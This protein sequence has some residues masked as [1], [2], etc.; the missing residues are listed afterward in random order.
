MSNKE[1]EV[2]N[3]DEIRSIVFTLLNAS[4]TIPTSEV[5]HVLNGLDR[6]VAKRIEEGKVMCKIELHTDPDKMCW[7]G[8]YGDRD[9]EL[10]RTGDT[11]IVAHINGEPVVLNSETDLDTIEWDE[12]VRIV[13]WDKDDAVN[14]YYDAYDQWKGHQESAVQYPPYKHH[15]E[16]P[17]YIKKL[18]AGKV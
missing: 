15:D 13:A 1:V 7:T 16:A 5:N 6:G 3:Y 2:V 12:W 17:N 4:G 18:K 9:K 10:R 11:Y 8:E 14:R